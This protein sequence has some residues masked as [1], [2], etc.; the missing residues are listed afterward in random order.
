MEDFPLILMLIP[1]FVVA[2]FWAVI[3]IERKHPKQEKIEQWPL[4][5]V[6]FNRGT[7]EFNALVDSLLSKPG[8]KLGFRDANGVYITETFLKWNRMGLAYYIY[9]DESRKMVIV[10]YNS[11]SSSN[12]TTTK[13]VKGLLSHFAC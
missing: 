6:D 13:T 12:E 9:L 10:H 4:R 1:W 3:Y 11:Y 5:F 2:V 7:D 8:F